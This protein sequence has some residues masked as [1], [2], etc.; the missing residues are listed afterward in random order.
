MPEALGWLS[1]VVTN[2]LSNQVGRGQ[3]LGGQFLQLQLDLVLQ[4]L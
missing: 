3:Q 2:L 1:Q 4:L